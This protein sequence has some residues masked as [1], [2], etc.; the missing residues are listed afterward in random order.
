MPLVAHSSGVDGARIATRREKKQKAEELLRKGVEERVGMEWCRQQRAQNYGA[1]LSVFPS[2]L[3]GTELSKNEFLDNARLQYDYA[4]TNLPNHCDGCGAPFTVDH[5]L[6]CKKGGLINQRHDDV[7]DEWGH[8]CGLAW[9]P[10]AVS[11]EP[12]VDDADA[13]G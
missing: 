12:Y 9:K 7:A 4:P 13:A 1:W 3:N 2:R 10:A 8:L 11:H 5:V 6:N